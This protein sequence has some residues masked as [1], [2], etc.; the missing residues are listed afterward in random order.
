MSFDERRQSLQARPD[1]ASLNAG[2]FNLGPESFIF[3]NPRW[4]QDELAAEMAQLGILPEYECYEIGMVVTSIELAKA[5]LKPGPVHMV[6]GMIGG[7]PATVE[8]I[9]QF[10]TMVPEG[11]PWWVTAIG[12]HNVP[13]MAA[14]LARGG[15]I[16][17]GLEDVAFVGPERHPPTNGELVKT[18]VE[19]CEI[20]G[21]PVATPQQGREI[22]GIDG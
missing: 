12:R 22:L 9:C 17:T 3:E 18:A 19:L 1:I 11:M 10:A 6:L 15:N 13:M 14:T 5:A 4:F 21:R 7:A 16:R 8:M 2:T 20:I